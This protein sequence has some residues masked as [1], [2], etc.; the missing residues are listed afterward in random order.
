MPASLDNGQ[1]LP[2]AFRKSLRTF[3]DRRNVYQILRQGR[4]KTVCEE[5]RCPNIGECFSNNTATFMIMG[6][7]CTRRCKFCSVTTKKPLP[8]DPEEPF[9]VADAALKMG[10]DYVVVTSVDRDDLPDLGAAHFASVVEAIKTTLPHS[11]VELLVPDFKGRVDLL[12]HVLSSPIDVFGHN[13]ESVDRIYQALRPQSNLSVTK[14][15]LAYASAH[16]KLTKSGMMVGL[17]ERDEEVF[18]TLS[19]L[20]DLGVRIV[21]IGQYLRPSLN[22][23][24]VHRFVSQDSYEQ[25]VEYGLKLGLAHVFAG[26]FV[27]SS[28]HAKEAHQKSKAA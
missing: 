19:T 1:R 22:H 5:A 20:F 17:G 2:L 28:Y 15:V 14:K 12:D 8:L 21:T 7:R 26:P 27:R 9:L 16:G 10:L 23:W 3:K 4:L 24:P 6:D 13:I 18:E 11:Q 25:F